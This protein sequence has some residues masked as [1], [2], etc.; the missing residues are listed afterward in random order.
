MSDKKQHIVANI[1][2]IHLN[3]QVLVVIEFTG[4][5]IMPSDAFIVSQ[6]EEIENETINDFSKFPL[7]ETEHTFE[8]PFDCHV[9]NV[10]RMQELYCNGQEIPR[11][12]IG[13]DE[14]V[15]HLNEKY[16]DKTFCIE[17]FE[18]IQYIEFILDK[19]HIDFINEQNLRHQAN[20]VGFLGQ[21]ALENY[22]T[23]RKNKRGF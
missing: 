10:K 3:N 4:D 23:E 1:D 22:L 11:V 12:D 15:L 16:S 18:N 13:C 2:S 5:N 14:V 19:F 6:F 8:D 21:I 7:L 17:D 9:D 20:K